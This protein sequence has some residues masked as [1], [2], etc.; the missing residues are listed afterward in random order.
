MNP[1]YDEVCRSCGGNGENDEGG[2]CKTCDGY[3]YLVTSK[4]HALIVFLSR[5]GVAF[6]MSPRAEE[7]MP[8]TRG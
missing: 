7:E 6:P 1:R 3:G 2:A 5:R 8:D 4:G